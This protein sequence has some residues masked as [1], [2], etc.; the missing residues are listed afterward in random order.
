M[1]FVA[2]DVRRLI[3][4]LRSRSER[5]YVGCYGPGFKSAKFLGEIFLRTRSVFQKAVTR[6]KMPIDNRSKFILRLVAIVLMTWTG[7]RAGSAQPA[8]RN[9][10]AIPIRAIHFSAPARKDLA[11]ALGFIRESLPK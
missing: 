8:I 2:A 7:T 11:A 10:A 5:P 4:F 9:S 3:P 1:N 6:P